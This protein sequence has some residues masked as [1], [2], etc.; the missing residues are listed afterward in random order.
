MESKAMVGKPAAKVDGV[1][2]D[3]KGSK[4]EIEGKVK[5]KI[6]TVDKGK[7]ETEAKVDAKANIGVKETK[8]EVKPE[9]IA[10]PKEANPV[11][12]TTPKTAVETPAETPTPEPEAKKPVIPTLDSLQEELKLVKQ[13]ILEHNQQI[14]E[15][16]EMATELQDMVSRKRKPTSNSKVQI[17][18]KLTGRVYP[19]KNNAYQ[20]LLK[21]G[22]LK[23]LVDK[24]V[25]GSDPE[26]NT[27]GWY[28]LKR[29]LPDRFEEITDKESDEKAKTTTAA[30]P[31]AK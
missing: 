22:D 24:G 28:A 6:E 26:K 23:E 19:S 11:V 4:T 17:K 30:V 25:F 7:T 29:A 14:I 1:K 15:L 10:E 16:Q 13:V 31:N 3:P 12:S 8:P 20:S 18:D 27:F 21:A 9:L 5:D 2:T